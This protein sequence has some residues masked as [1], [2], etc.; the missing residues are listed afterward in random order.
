VREIGIME[1]SGRGES[2]RNSRKRE[3]LEGEKDVLEGV[4]VQGEEGVGRERGR[5]GREI[6]QSYPVVII[7]LSTPPP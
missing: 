6:H 7:H 5:G 2:G 4:E 3:F 1:F